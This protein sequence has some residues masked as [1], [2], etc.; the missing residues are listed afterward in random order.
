MEEH[1]FN[2]LVQIKYSSIWTWNEERKRGE[3]R[4]EVDGI[5]SYWNVKYDKQTKK[6]F[7]FYVGT[8][9]AFYSLDTRYLITL[10]IMN[11]YNWF[12]MLYNKG[13]IP[14]EKDVHCYSELYKYKDEM[15]R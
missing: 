9:S 2:H 7:A 8:P 5:K 6:V 14:E 10:F 13:V 12:Y 4:K 3:H 11:P 1:E 15:F